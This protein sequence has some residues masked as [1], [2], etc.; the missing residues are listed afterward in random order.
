MPGGGGWG[1]GRAWPC[2]HHHSHHQPVRAAKLLGASEDLLADRR[3][4]GERLETR[5]QQRDPAWP[6]SVCSLKDPMGP[7]QDC[8]EGVLKAKGTV[9]PRAT[10]H[11]G[12]QVTPQPAVAQI[13]PSFRA[14]FCCFYQ[15]RHHKASGSTE[16]RPVG[17]G[18][19]APLESI[20]SPP[21]RCPPGKVPA[22]SRPQKEPQLS[23]SPSV[24]K[25]HIR[26]AFIPGLDA[27]FVLI[28]LQTASIFKEGGRGVGVG[29]LAPTQPIC[30]D[31]FC[32][33]EEGA[34]TC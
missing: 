16:L 7:A 20:S 1:Q 23:A 18:V 11:P 25:A 14:T 32:C 24:K 33:S 4:W 9:M 26:P 17:D 6:T 22:A 30:S 34:G 15:Q 2:H 29:G 31:H 3:F 27:V 5:K 12:T 13:N 21:T 28:S 19:L 8:A 10:S